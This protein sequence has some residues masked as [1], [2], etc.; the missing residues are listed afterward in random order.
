MVGDS[1]YTYKFQ[2]KQIPE[3]KNAKFKIFSRKD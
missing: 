1:V 2:Y 3:K